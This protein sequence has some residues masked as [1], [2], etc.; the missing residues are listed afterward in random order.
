[1]TYNECIIKAPVPSNGNRNNKT[2]FLQ[3]PKGRKM[4]SLFFTFYA[5]FI[6]Q[7]EDLS[8]L[9]PLGS[10]DLIPSSRFGLIKCLVRLF[11]E[12]LWTFKS[13]WSAYGDAD[14]YS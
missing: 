5:S 3:T 6:H 11:N 13:L 14:A 1:M 12:F 7:L 4:Q 8:Q 10:Y 9:T 2:L